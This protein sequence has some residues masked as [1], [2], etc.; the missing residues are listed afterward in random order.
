MIGV[1][2]YEE[3][4]KKVRNKKTDTRTEGEKPKHG[5][6]SPPRSE[7]VS[8]SLTPRQMRFPRRPAPPEPIH[9]RAVRRNETPI[10]RASRSRSLPVEGECSLSGHHL[11]PTVE[12]SPV[13]RLQ[14][15]SESA[16]AGA[17]ERAAHFARWRQAV[18]DTQILERKF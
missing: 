12:D 8:P 5:I 18:I 1:V 3:I 11:H 2:V 4:V 17:E 10:A 9:D 6:P 16:E 7:A 13:P 15:M 14:E